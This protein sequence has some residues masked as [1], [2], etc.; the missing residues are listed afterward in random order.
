MLYD[1]SS[2]SFVSHLSKFNKFLDVQHVAE[3]FKNMY[4]LGSKRSILDAAWKLD[5]DKFIILNQYYAKIDKFVWSFVSFEDM[6]NDAHNFPELTLKVFDSW[7]EGMSGILT[8]SK[9]LRCHTDPNW[10]LVV[11]DVV[12]QS[13]DFEADVRRCISFWF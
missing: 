5:T 11:S 10:L 2:S 12:L 8:F 9:S 3:Q 1:T 4:W 13:I 7:L 6:M